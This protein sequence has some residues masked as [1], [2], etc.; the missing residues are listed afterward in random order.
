MKKIILFN[1]R[2]NKY[3]YKAK[4]FFKYFEHESKYNE[5]IHG[6][7]F[8]CDAYIFTSKKELNDMIQ[9]FSNALLNRP[10]LMSFEVIDV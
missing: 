9:R 7:T 5:G 6:Y 2:I 1:L 3:V 4:Y 10:K 8:A